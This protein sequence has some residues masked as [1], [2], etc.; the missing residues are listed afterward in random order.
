MDRGAARPRELG[1]TVAPADPRLGYN[2]RISG[3]DDLLSS[4]EG[5]LVPDATSVDDESDLALLYED[6]CVR[7]VGRRRETILRGGCQI[8]S[9]EVERQLRAYPAVHDVCVI[10]V[11]HDVLGSW[12]A[13]ASWVPISFASSTNSRWAGVAR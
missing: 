9:R 6:G 10:G 13:R 1:A 3:F 2:D 7:I 8:H 12:C 5:R 11:P 4:G